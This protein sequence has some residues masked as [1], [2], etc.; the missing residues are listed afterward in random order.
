M[1]KGFTFIEL[2]LII[3][4]IGII[5]VVAIPKMM[6]IGEVRLAAALEKVAADLRYAR[7]FAMNHNSRS[8]VVFSA[9]EYTIYEESAGAWQII[10]D[11]ATRDDYTILL[12]SGLYRG[13]TI[14]SVTFDGGSEVQ[15]DALGAP[16]ISFE[17]KLQNNGVV[18]LNCTGVDRTSGI[19]VYPVT[20]RIDLIT[21]EEE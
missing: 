2:V 9:N 1:N 3:V 5:A 15:F 12:D 8:K 16:Y 11:P 20:G 17:V 4:I 19:R 18:M 14:A 6:D 21:G 10:E 7:E 13:V